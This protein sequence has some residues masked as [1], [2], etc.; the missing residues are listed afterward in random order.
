MQ[1]ISAKS[2]ARFE[3]TFVTGASMADRR[4]NVPES[5]GLIS[6]TSDNCGSIWARGQV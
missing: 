2:N 3:Q 5:E 4:E 1:I 6:S